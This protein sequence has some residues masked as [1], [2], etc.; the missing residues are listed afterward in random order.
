MADRIE[1]APETR[2]F[3]RALLETYSHATLALMI[4]LGSRTGLWK[5]L[6]DAPGTS[7]EIARRAHL[8]ERYVREWL[9]AV[10]AAGIVTYEPRRRTFSLDPDRAVCLTGDSPYNL[11]AGSRMALV[12]APHAAALL[13]AFRR[14]GGVPYSAYLPDF[15]RMMDEL[16]RRRYDALLVPA[17]IPL[18]RGLAERLRAG[19][20][21]A[22]V[23]CGSAHTT[24]LLAR[25]FPR[26][27]FIAIDDAPAPLRM[28]R[29]EARA[30]GLTNVEHVRGEVERIRDFGPFDA[31]TMFD[32]IHDLADPPAALRAV[33]R[34]LKPS[35]ILFAEEPR[36]SSR[37]EA[38]LGNP[39]A[40]FLYGIS[41]SY[42]LPVSLAHGSAGYGT[43][44]G[45]ERARRLLRASGLRRVETHDAPANSLA[46]VYVAR[47]R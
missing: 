24:H 6:A 18:A 25:A 16:N 15:P 11:A 43:A 30:W 13:R 34:S 32:A 19:A 26:S 33:V 10:A 44:W 2:R 20:R 42:C 5:T 4:D 9:S 21:L 31:V 39:G 12:G 36:A 35:G 28:A 45:I 29:A 38:N 41:V 47:R 3:A 22:D 27:T 7:V 40:A 14:G 17:Y 37:L 46:V 23:G 1:L 8:T